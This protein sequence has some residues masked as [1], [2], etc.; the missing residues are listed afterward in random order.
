MRK[1]LV[2]ALLA[3]TLLLPGL[4]VAKPGAVGTPAADFSLQE[5]PYGPMHTLNEHQGEVVLL[6]M[7]GYG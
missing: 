5:Y 2:A 1:K 6:F 3:G 4:A 7:I